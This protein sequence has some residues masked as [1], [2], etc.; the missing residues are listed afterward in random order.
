MAV[1]VR[2]TGVA[3]PDLLAPNEPH[4]TWNLTRIGLRHRIVVR[5]ATPVEY[6]HVIAQ[7]PAP[8]TI[9]PFGTTITLVLGR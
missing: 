9:V 2:Y 4:P 6:G 1:R 3:V 5:Q 7:R 8:G